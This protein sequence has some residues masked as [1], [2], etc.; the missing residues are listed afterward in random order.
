MG[1][2]GG[3]YGFVGVVRAILDCAHCWWCALVLCFDWFSVAA[4][5]FAV[6]IDEP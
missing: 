3:A 5:L 4:Y 1:C 2:L 6:I